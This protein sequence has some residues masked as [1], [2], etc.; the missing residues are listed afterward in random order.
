MSL[1]YEELKNMKVGEVFYESSSMCNIKFTVIEEPKETFDGEYHQVEWVGRVNDVHYGD[2]DYLVTKEAMHYG[3]SIYKFPAYAGVPNYGFDGNPIERFDEDDDNDN[4]DSNFID[5]DKLRKLSK[6]DSDVDLHDKVIKLGEET[7]E[8]CQAYLGYSKSTNSS[9]SSDNSIDEIVE[10]AC[11][12]INVAIDILNNIE[13]TTD[14]TYD[15]IR[16]MF[17]KKLNKWE[18]KQNKGWHSHDR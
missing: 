17:G 16:D 15:V 8:L 5:F 12:V 3:P 6:N 13:M 4:I 14:V 7:G 9:V 2:V 10:E 1:R 11:D 18:S